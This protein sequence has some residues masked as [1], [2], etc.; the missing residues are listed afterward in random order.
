V[1]GDDALGE[2]CTYDPDDGTDSCDVHG[3]CW[4]PGEG[5]TGTCVEFCKN[6]PD[7]PECSDGTVCY[8]R[9][10]QSGWPTY[11]VTTCDPFTQ[12]CAE[13]LGC[14]WWSYFAFIC[15]PAGDSVAGD[16]CRFDGDC[17]P[18]TICTDGDYLLDCELACCTPFCDLTAP[19]CAP[20]LECIAYFDEGSAPEG[21]E[22]LG[23]CI[24]PP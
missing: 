23:L 11:C 21:F 20:D 3:Y 6:S 19:D 15:Q 12:E 2:P 17:Q 13:G 9:G 22:S 4:V 1:T 18:G 8:F 24:L 5:T 16:P 7:D 14:T 10:G